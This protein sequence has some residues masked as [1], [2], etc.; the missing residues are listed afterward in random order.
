DFA[1]FLAEK[2]AKPKRRKLKLDW[3]G[4]SKNS[5][6]SILHWSCRRSRLTG[7]ATDISG[8]YFEEISSR[9]SFKTDSMLMD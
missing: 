9:C 1:L 8:R 6:I 3:A 7:G 4:V 5:V 2:R